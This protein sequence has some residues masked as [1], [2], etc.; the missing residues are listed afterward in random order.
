MVRVPRRDA[1]EPVEMANTRPHRRTTPV[2]RSVLAPPFDW[3]PT[4]ARMA[5]FGSHHP[6]ALA[7]LLEPDEGEG[8]GYRH[9]GKPSG[10]V[11]GGACRE[12]KAGDP[13][14]GNR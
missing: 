8:L 9:C 13:V 6:P 12:G 2:R 11:Y 14:T 1:L 10:R 3:L 5:D 4:M 7:F